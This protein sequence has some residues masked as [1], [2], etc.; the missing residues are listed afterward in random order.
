MKSASRLRVPALARFLTL[1][2][3][4]AALAAVAAGSASAIGAAGSTLTPSFPTGQN[5][6]YVTPVTAEFQ[7]AVDG[8][9]SP[10]FSPGDYN[11]TM[12][13]ACT[14]A[15]DPAGGGGPFG[16]PGVF[17]VAV[18]LTTSSANPGGTQVECIGDY[19]RSTYTC[20]PGPFGIPICG[21]GPV[22]HFAFVPNQRTVK[23]DLSPPV[24]V[25]ATHAPAN[26]NGWHNEPSMVTY[27]GDDPNSGIAFCT[28]S[29]IGPPDGAAKQTDGFC[30]NEAG[31]AAQAIVHY[32][33]D[34]TAPTLAPTVSPNPVLRG[35]AATASPNAGTDLSGI[36]AASCDPVDT[37]TV[38]AHMV[39]C[40]A[41]DKAGNSANASAGY[42]V[43]LGFTGFAAP[44]DNDLVNVAKA[45]QTV[46]LKFR[47]HDANGPVTDLSSDAASV[48]VA[49]LAC[50]LGDTTDQIEEYASGASGLQNLGDGNYQFNWKTPKDYASSCKTLKVDVGDSVDHTAQF[51]FTK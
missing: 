41:T 34:A 4:I 27:D 26:P 8:P 5:G 19:L 45:G 21:F 14:A 42:D 30:E 23:I 36:D 18:T 28:T 7:F 11:E 17:D 44:V 32:K 39:S 51:R 29:A 46:P 25:S 24:G 43:V 40:T 37:S 49:S 9:A 33:Y 2:G 3:L 35:A 1:V 31:L 10:L 13:A 12:T 16:F 20:S 47:V 15:G 6:W 50:D 48:T 38:G 22:V